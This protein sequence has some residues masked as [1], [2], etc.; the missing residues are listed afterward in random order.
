MR[1]AHRFDLRAVGQLLHRVAVLCVVLQQDGHL[2]GG[3]LQG[4][5]VNNNNNKSRCT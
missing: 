5:P 4:V 3:G 2:E 1:P